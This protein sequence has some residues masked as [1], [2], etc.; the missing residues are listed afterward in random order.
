MTTHCVTLCYAHYHQNR[1][2]PSSL[3]LARDH[4]KLV[5]EVHKLHFGQRLGQHICDLLICG[6]VLELHS[7]LLHHIVY[8]LCLSNTKH[9]TRLLP[10]APRN[11]Y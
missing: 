10:A 1:V 8:I 7:S 2:Y 5:P 11:H 6:N 3:P 4:T 9:H